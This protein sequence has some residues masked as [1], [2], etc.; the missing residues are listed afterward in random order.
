MNLVHIWAAKAINDVLTIVPGHYL[1]CS[2]ALLI[3]GH[4]FL[5]SP[6]SRPGLRRFLLLIKLT[7]SIK[8]KA[9]ISL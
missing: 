2:Q 7:A 9:V 4:I 3:H 5:P 8:D 6:L 1:S